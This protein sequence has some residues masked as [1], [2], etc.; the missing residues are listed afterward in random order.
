MG[1]TTVNAGARTIRSASQKTGVTLFT[2]LTAGLRMG[3]NGLEL[4]ARWTDS[5]LYEQT[6]DQEANSAMREGE[7]R[8]EFVEVH[9]ERAQRHAKII[10]EAYDLK[11]AYAEAN[12]AYDEVMSPFA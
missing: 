6:R 3:G 9:M 8:E 4:G 5:M 11:K 10:G 1:K 12:A 2:S 7:R